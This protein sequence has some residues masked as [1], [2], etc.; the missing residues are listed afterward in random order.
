MGFISHSPL[1][2]KAFEKLDIEVLAM[3]CTL[4]RRQRQLSW[5]KFSKSAA[6][7]RLPSVVYN[8]RVNEL[9]GGIPSELRT[10]VSLEF[11]SLRN[12]MLTGGI[13]AELSEM[14]ELRYLD[15]HGNGLTGEVPGS[16]GGLAK[17][18]QLFLSEND[19]T[20]EIPSELGDLP[21]LR[22]LWLGGNQLMGCIPAGLGDNE[23]GDE[24]SLGLS[25][26]Q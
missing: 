14:T 15:L 3:W 9:T 5:D 4:T 7:R 21:E 12:N 2:V 20:G 8:V 13:P 10:L 17:L 22:A 26:C 1:P 18:R 24:D 25:N 19:L 23:Y 16:L 11:M 6:F